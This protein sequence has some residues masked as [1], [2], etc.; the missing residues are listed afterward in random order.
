MS[1]W[2][3][4]PTSRHPSPSSTNSQTIKP[5]PAPGRPPCAPTCS[6]PLDT[7]SPIQNEEPTKAQLF[8]LDDGGQ[9]IT[10]QFNPTTF[11]FTRKVNWTEGKNAAMPWPSLSFS[12]GATDS[13]SVSLLLD[14]SEGVGGKD[15]TKSVLDG[16]LA[17]Y[18]LT[19]PLEISGSEGKAIRP[20]VVAFLWERFQFQGVVE[21][22]DVEV[23]LFDASGRP[24]RA[25]LNLTI[26]GK[27]MSGAAS[28][29]DFF[30]VVYKPAKG[31]TAKP[32]SG[33]KRVAIWA[34][35]G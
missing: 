14:E 7:P 22:L 24:R 26:K 16:I 35:K 33:D 5:P 9:S 2:P 25:T 15:N 31:K 3:S 12:Y 17:Y 27:A 34:G 29:D 8:C 1:P 4:R 6:N 21:D 19:M 20:P 10:F 13:L 23:Q 28:S 32:P 30:S 18:K 11:K